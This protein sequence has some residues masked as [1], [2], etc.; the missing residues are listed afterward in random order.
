M[1]IELI[2][3]CY[4]RRYDEGRACGAI[5]GSVKAHISVYEKTGKIKENNCRYYGRG[6]CKF[7]TNARDWG[8]CP[9]TP[10][11]ILVREYS[12]TSI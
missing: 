11:K 10:N 8:K 2:I 5:E 1:A 6:K 4:G 3:D 9:Y 12:Q 7:L